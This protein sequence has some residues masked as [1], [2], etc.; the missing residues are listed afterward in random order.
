MRS[1]G[2]VQGLITFELLN[3][4]TSNLTYDYILTISK[5]LSNKVMGL[6][7]KSSEVMGSNIQALINFEQLDLETS[8]LTYDYILT[9][10]RPSWSTKVMGSMSNYDNF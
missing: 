3:L 6:S 9:I 1:W 7:S 4:E 5:S 10:F 8:N 2:Q